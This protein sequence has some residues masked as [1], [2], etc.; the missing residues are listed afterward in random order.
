MING[1][2]RAVSA[3]LDVLPEGI[4]RLPGTL[5]DA[6]G[7]AVEDLVDLRQRQLHLLDEHVRDLA[8]I[9]LELD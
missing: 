1:P 6:S 4:T 7:K 3:I 5:L 8:D 2:I 9:S